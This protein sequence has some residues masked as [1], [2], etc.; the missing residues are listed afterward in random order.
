MTI[1]FVTSSYI[2]TDLIF[3]VSVVVI[4]EVLSSRTIIYA[5]DGLVCHDMSAVSKN[6]M[7]GVDVY[8]ILVLIL[9]ERMATDSSY[10]GAL[11]P[12][13]VA[14]VRMRPLP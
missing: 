6:S 5:N 14:F 11:V 1:S 4:I 10:G 12:K 2:L 3:V 8:L 9:D 13:Q 7:T